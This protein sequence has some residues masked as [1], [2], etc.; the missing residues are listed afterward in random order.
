MSDLMFRLGGDT[1][2]MRRKLDELGPYFQEGGKKLAQRLNLGIAGGMAALGFLLVQTIRRAAG[3]A[4]TDAMEAVRESSKLGVTVTEFQQLKQLADA[5]GQ[6]IDTMV[7]SLKL[8]GQAAQEMRTAMAGVSQAAGGTIGEDNAKRIAFAG[9]V[10]S[11]AW[12]GTKR[13][14]GTGL[15]YLAEFGSRTIGNVTGVAKGIGALLKGK[16]FAEAYEVMTDE[17]AQGATAADTAN[18]RQIVASGRAKIAA[19]LV[20]RDEQ[21]KK[22][23]EA[24]AKK[25]AAAA[26]KA[27][28]A[29]RMDKYEIDELSRVGIGHARTGYDQKSYQEQS[30]DYLKRIEANTGDLKEMGD[31]DS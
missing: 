29:I 25:K 15:G 12:Q 17:I 27:L 3:E 10:G 9:Q 11:T 6:S 28:S 26:K 14:V 23:A 30:L 18:T 20:D 22:D 1:S 8:G 2:P 21:A 24:D 31:V 7:K 4:V 5:T 19:S 16:G 13:M